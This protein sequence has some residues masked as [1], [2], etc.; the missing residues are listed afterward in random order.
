MYVKSSV[1]ECV[2]VEIEQFVPAVLALERAN[3]H[4]GYESVKT[5]TLVTC[6]CWYSQE[7]MYIV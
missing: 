1:K 7:Y 2:V 6:V 4:V 3:K 5:K